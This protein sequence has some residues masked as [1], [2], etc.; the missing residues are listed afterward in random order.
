MSGENGLVLITYGGFAWIGSA[1]TVALS[2]GMNPLEM[3]S[4]GLNGKGTK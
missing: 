3:I 2:E 1:R 4:A